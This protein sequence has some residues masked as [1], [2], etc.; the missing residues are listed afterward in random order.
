MLRDPD[1]NLTCQRPFA[2]LRGP[3]VQRCRFGSDA[4]LPLSLEPAG[5]II[6]PWPVSIRPV[7]PPLNERQPLS[8]DTSISCQFRAANGMPLHHRITWTG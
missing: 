3:A 5:R 6:N 4:R 1:P 7:Q 8:R 2:G